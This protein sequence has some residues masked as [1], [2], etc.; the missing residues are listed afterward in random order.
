MAMTLD[1]LEWQRLSEHVASFAS[2]GATRDALRSG[3]PVDMSHEASTSLHIETEEAYTLEQVLGSRIDLR[4][5]I[6]LGPLVTHASKGGELDGESIVATGESLQAASNLLKM[7]KA[8]SG[9]SAGDAGSTG[10]ADGVASARPLRVLVG[11]F[12]GIPEQASLRMS[13]AECFDEAGRVREAAEPSLGALREAR[14]EVSAAAR[15]ELS[16]LVQLKADALASTAPSVRDDR[17]V[18]QVRA[19]RRHEVAGVV[20]DVSAS[21]AT[22]YVEPKGLEPTNTKLRQLAKREAAIERAVRL[23]FSKLIGAPKA[24]GE[25]RALSAAVGRVDSACARARYSA[26]LGGAPVTLCDPTEPSE[27]HLAALRHPLLVWRSVGEP[28]NPDA[29]VPMDIS[30]APAVRVVVITGPNT[31]GKTVCLKTLGMAA[32]MAK[33]GLRVLC[34]PSAIDGRVRIPVRARATTDPTRPTRTDPNPDRP[35]PTDLTR[36]T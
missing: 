19:K 15:R 22:V 18:L 14:R 26:H 8:A 32:L 9:E 20:R 16:R 28:A 13:I 4:G 27:L 17:Y 31:G 12:D 2:I 34:Q 7:L 29:M 11:L 21:G 5:F 33:A 10:V 25:L 24:A 1:L 36:P 23:R 35:D 6:E 30:I 3:L